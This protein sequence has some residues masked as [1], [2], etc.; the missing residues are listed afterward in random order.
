MTKTELLFK[1]QNVQVELKKKFG[2]EKIALFGSYAKGEER[3][4]SDVDILVIE[5]KKKNA[6]TLIRAK[7]FL[8]S[9]LN[10]EVDLGLYDSVRPFIKKRIDDELINV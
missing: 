7:N 4:D 5:M 6:F 8:S 1:L 9:Y 10:K 2:I 3:Q